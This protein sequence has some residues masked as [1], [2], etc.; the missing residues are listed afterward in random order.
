MT[1]LPNDVNSILGGMKMAEFAL[2]GFVFV[3]FGFQYPRVAEPTLE[4]DVALV[5]TS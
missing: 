3:S 2:G 5:S 4:V 1:A